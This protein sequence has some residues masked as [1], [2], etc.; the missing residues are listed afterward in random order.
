MKKILV[1]ILIVSMLFATACIQPTPA[2]SQSPTP[3]VTLEPTP[4]PTPEL[5]P[6]P[7]VVP[8][9]EPTKTPSKT[10]VLDAKV[11]HVK[12]L[13]ASF[14]DKTRIEVTDEMAANGLVE[15]NI[16]KDGFDLELLLR[17]SGYLY[18]SYDVDIDGRIAIGTHEDLEYTERLLYPESSEKYLYIMCIIFAATNEEEQYKEILDFNITEYYA[19][20]L[21]NKNI[22]VN[23]TFDVEMSNDFTYEKPKEQLLMLKIKADDESY[24]T[25]VHTLSFVSEYI[26]ERNVRDA[27]GNYFTRTGDDE[28]LPVGEDV[29]GLDIS[30]YW[31]DGVKIIYNGY[32]Y[33]HLVKRFSSAINA[34]K[35]MDVLGCRPFAVSACPQVYDGEFI[36]GKDDGYVYVLFKVGAENELFSVDE[37]LKAKLE[38]GLLDLTI[39]M[40]VK[41]YNIEIKE[42]YEIYSSVVVLLKIKKSTLSCNINSVNLDVDVTP[43]DVIGY[44]PSYIEPTPKPS[45]TPAPTP[46][47]E[48]TKKEQ[49]AQIVDSLT[50][51]TKINFNT[52]IKS[53]MILE[54]H[55]LKSGFDSSILYEYGFYTESAEDGVDLWK[56]ESLFFGYSDLFGN[57]GKN[58]GYL[59]IVLRAENRNFIDFDIV[60]SSDSNSRY[61]RTEVDVDLSDYDE[62]IGTQNVLLLFVVKSDEYASLEFNTRY[63]TMEYVKNLIEKTNDDDIISVKELPIKGLEIGLNAT[64]AYNFTSG[65][66][67]VENLPVIYSHFKYVEKEGYYGFSITQYPQAYTGEE[68]LGEDDGYVYVLVAAF[69][70]NITYA[71]N[72]I[73]DTAFNN[74]VLVLTIDMYSTPKGSFVS[75]AIQDEL[76]I[77]KI[78]RAS[79]ACDIDEVCLNVNIK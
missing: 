61:L 46:V 9:P 68:I 52:E 8:T 53:D 42:R 79:L 62:S 21:K 66:V 31:S 41:K 11:A 67:S 36:Y 73:T 45:A 70:G 74:G 59:M 10:P 29:N 22:S 32:D 33:K 1:V 48:E 5:T 51:K 56:S 16:L 7:T 71:F 64:K 76:V 78:A 34:P 57:T 55:L 69:A 14:S 6:E 47:P 40:S 28:Y 65:Q 44:W 18:A 20:D 12:S 77:V 39:K 37:I 25:N 43:S 4:E 17:N 2:P 15:A 75:T 50:E 19:S 72:S 30:A 38:N 3:E 54:A 26:A 23:I 60:A 24:R 63:S 27:I 13:I 58:C 35:W 49:V